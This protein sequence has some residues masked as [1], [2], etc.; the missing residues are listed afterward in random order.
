MERG[1]RIPPIDA[2]FGNARGKNYLLAI[3]INAYRNWPK[4][5]NAVKDASDIVKVL[6]EQYQF[7]PD[8]VIHLFDGEATE[9]NIYDRIRDLKKVISENDSL[10][11][12]YSGHG[13]YD[14]DFN[15]GYW[16]PVDAEQGREGRYISNSD[17]ITRIN[18][19]SS[20]HTL[21]VVD[22]CF[23]G[24]LVIQKRQGLTDERFRS[25]RILA[26][27]R[28]ETV[29]DGIPGENSPF[30]KGIITFL[31]KNSTKAVNTTALVQYVKGYVEDKANQTPVEGR[32]P[33]SDDEGGEFVFHLK[34][35]E[36]DLWEKVGKENTIESY[37]N[38]L[39]YY[40]NGVY[41]ATAN[42]EILALREE[43]V[44][45]NACRQDTEVDYENY[46]KKYVP[47]G[48]YIEEARQRLQQ[49]R[50][51]Q[52]KRRQVLEELAQKEN[53][54]D[55]IKRQFQQLVADAEGLLSQKSP[56]AAREKY[57]ESLQYFLEGFT[58]GQE[59]IEGQ[60][61]LCSN[62]IE[63]L[64]LYSQ[65]EKAMQTG[66]YR[67]AMQFFQSALRINYN[68]K[69]EEYV[70]ECRKRLTPPPPP[71]P[72]KQ[73]TPTPPPKQQ[74]V[75]HQQVVHRES[76]RKKRSPWGWVIGLLAI[77]AVAVLGAIA[78][79]EYS[80][81]TSYTPDYSYDE[82][83]ASSSAPPETKLG[84]VSQTNADLVI[85]SWLVTQFDFGNTSYLNQNNMD[86]L[87]ALK[88]QY[89]FYPGGNLQITN[90]YGQFANNVYSVSGD[91][92][93]I[94]FGYNTMNGNI[95]YLDDNTMKLSFPVNYGGYT[96]DMFMAL[97]RVGR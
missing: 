40:P 50:D 64:D 53:E 66:N 28:A 46:L 43:E 13:H 86:N 44:W 48:K 97:E 74:A 72:P 4:L 63:F 91:Y 26:S 19:I 7:E 23:S 94:G 22:A 12:Y 77:A 56:Q 67:L 81:S 79:N 58:P 10:V 80:A 14:E 32:V 89:H 75:H 69:A 85:G 96:Y 2:P 87:F 37:E 82:P 31:K 54:R 49:V 65:G 83:E 68:P 16:V 25:R 29:A 21:L 70:R 11:V 55:R 24:T 57:R 35:T 51:A 71:L 78:Y 52:D 42:R 6:T 60:I 84:A 3:G 90:N 73:Q 88:T 62:N 93:S 36:A 39:D 17:L 76:P 38:Y 41:T 45:Q 18:A 61:N 20:K 95:Q 15:M 5:N 9:A 33:N 8:Q 59:Y 1:V 34:M 30:A 27:G 92:I 47:S